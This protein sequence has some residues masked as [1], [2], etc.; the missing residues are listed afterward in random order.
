MVYGASDETGSSPREKAV[1]PTRILS[2]VYHALGIDPH[3]MVMNHLNQP[4]ELIK[5]EP[6]LE[7]F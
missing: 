1:H 2:S 6:V 5:A 7:L 4:R 3:T